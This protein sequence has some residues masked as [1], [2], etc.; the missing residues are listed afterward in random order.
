VAGKTGTAQ[1]V[2]I[3]DDA[4][5]DASK[6][7]E[8]HRDHALFIA[9][10]PVEDPRVAVAVMVENGEHG[11]STAAPVARSVMDAYLLP[12]AGADP[13]ILTAVGALP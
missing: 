10:A 1:V 12:R 13:E 9:F 3:A 6:L 7:D 11:G 5:Y 8:R 4:T 2:G